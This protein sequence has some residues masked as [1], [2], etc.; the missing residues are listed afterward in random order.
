MKTFH[1]QA[2]SW[3][4]KLF[5]EPTLCILSILLFSFLCQSRKEIFSHKKSSYTLV[6]DT[7][8]VQ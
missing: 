3:F 4:E 2:A 8:Q 5:K 7:V 6:T 1:R